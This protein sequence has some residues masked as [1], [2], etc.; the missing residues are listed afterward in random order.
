MKSYLKIFLLITLSSC[1]YAPMDQT[2]P[3]IIDKV[4]YNDKG[5]CDYYGTS[6]YYMTI[7]LTSTKFKFRDSCGK[8]SIGD[9]VKFTKQ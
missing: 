5:T 1:G 7:T 9:T 2:N 3:L 4:E 8:F 6:N